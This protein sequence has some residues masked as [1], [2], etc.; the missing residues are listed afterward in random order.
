MRNYISIG[1]VFVIAL[2]IQTVICVALMQ[3]IQ[4]DLEDLKGKITK[5]E[6][7]SETARH[8]LYAQKHRISL[9]ES[10]RDRLLD[11]VHGLAVELQSARI[12][13]PD[14]DVKVFTGGPYRGIGPVSKRRTKHGK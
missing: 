4:K 9:Q 7:I 14:H 2:I 6:T 12:L 3:G 10:E 5:L 8:E 1:V 13:N 11:A